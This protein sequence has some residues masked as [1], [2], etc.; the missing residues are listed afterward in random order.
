MF[1]GMRRADRQANDEQA[2]LILEKAEYGVLSTLSENG[3]PYGV[4]ISYVYVDDCIYLHSAKTGHK[5]DNISANDK[6]SF[7]VV[8]QKES[9]P[10]KFSTSYQ[11]VVYFG[12]A[13]QIEGEEKKAALLALI[14]KYAPGHIESGTEYVNNAMEKTIVVKIVCEH[15]T[16][17]VRPL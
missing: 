16:G 6:V 9:I 5:L 13:S 14:K 3:Y 4:P 12:Q 15:M 1:R 11:S 7:C 10:E 8:S 2:K 17:K